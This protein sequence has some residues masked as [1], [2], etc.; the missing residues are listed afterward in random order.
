MQCPAGRAVTVE[1]PH[2][3]STGPHLYSHGVQARKRLMNKPVRSGDSGRV[4][5]RVSKHARSLS[6][7]CSWMDVGRAAPPWGQSNCSG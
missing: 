7:A 1:S 5:R 4:G 3:E 6:S 2:G